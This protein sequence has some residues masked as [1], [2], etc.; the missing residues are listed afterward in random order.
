MSRVKLSRR[1]GTFYYTDSTPA[2]TE[3]KTSLIINKDPKYAGCQIVPAGFPL[4]V[5]DDY[6]V[7]RAFTASFLYENSTGSYIT[8]MGHT[9]IINSASELYLGRV[10]GITLS[11]SDEVGM[12]H[13]AANKDKL[14]SM[15]GYMFTNA[16]FIS[17]LAQEQQIES[18]YPP[19]DVAKLFD[20]EDTEIEGA[21]MVATDGTKPDKY[22]ILIE[23]VAENR[24]ATTDGDY[25]D[26]RI[27]LVDQNLILRAGGLCQAMSGGFITA[28]DNGIE[29]AVGAFS[30]VSASDPTKGFGIFITD[31]IDEIENFSPVAKT[32]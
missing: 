6:G 32:K 22:S 7:E 20:G 9:S 31:Y 18:A 17:R 1:R 29:Y 12:L 14:L 15:N 24:I 8:G 13:I 10:V 26:F 28:K 11:T 27:R 3:E 19:M 16:G 2:I 5:V 25:Y 4:V 23:R 30:A 21:L